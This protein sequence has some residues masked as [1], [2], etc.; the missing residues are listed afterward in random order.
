MVVGIN[1]A[2]RTQDAGRVGASSV[3]ELPSKIYASE[4]LP[5]RGFARFLNFA[6]M[7]LVR[8]DNSREDFRALV[9]RLDAHLAVTDEDEHDFYHQYNGL[10][11]IKHVVMAYEGG[12]PIAC[13]AIKAYDDSTMEVKRMFTAEAARGQ[14]IAVIVLGELEDWAKELGYTRCLL[15]TGKRQ[16]YAVR[17]YEKC[18]YRVVPNYGQYAGMENSVCMEKSFT[19]HPF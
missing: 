8:T 2:A 17:L 15:E 5:G 10:D 7:K 4:E 6:F 9:K 12:T 11:A 19:K 13:G 18:G 1:V 3:G 16:P 14:G